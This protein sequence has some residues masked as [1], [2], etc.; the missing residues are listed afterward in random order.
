MYI[1]TWINKLYFSINFEFWFL[2]L[3]DSFIP[4]LLSRKRTEVLYIGRIQTRLVVAFVFE[5][6]VLVLLPPN[7]DDYREASYA[8]VQPCN[9]DRRKNDS[10]NHMATMRISRIFNYSSC[11]LEKATTSL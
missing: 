7:G 8:R 3:A 1:A 11:Y 10:P 6:S 2:G 5:F 9:H 4:I